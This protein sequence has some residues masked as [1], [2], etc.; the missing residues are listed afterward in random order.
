[1]LINTSAERKR[2]VAPVPPEII[3]GDAEILELLQ[4]GQVTNLS[5]QFDASVLAVKNF[6]NPNELMFLPPKLR[7]EMDELDQAADQAAADAKSEIQGVLSEG[8]AKP[9][10]PE[11]TKQLKIDL[12]A[13]EA[14]IKRAEAALAQAKKNK[15]RAEQ[16][17]L[18]IQ[19]RN[20]TQRKETLAARL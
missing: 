10:N 2:G 5:G 18:K 4:R 8:Q 9:V 13:V 11:I 16:A 12:Q 19:L 15:D 1:M 3:G 6:I 7:Q 14:N 20:L 17:K